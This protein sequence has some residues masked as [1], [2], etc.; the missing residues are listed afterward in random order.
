[1]CQ[2]LGYNVTKMPNLV[3]SQF[4]TD[5]ELQLTT[6]TPLIQSGC[7]SQLQGRVDFPWLGCEGES[8]RVGACAFSPRKVTFQ[9]TCKLQCNPTYEGQPASQFMSPDCPNP[10]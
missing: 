8:C 9:K 1:M 2:N 7:S 10:A 3:G 5:A 6:F 4:Q